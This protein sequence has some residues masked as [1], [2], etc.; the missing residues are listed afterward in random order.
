M[1]EGH[2][3]LGDDTADRARDASVRILVVDG[4]DG[5]RYLLGAVLAEEGF[6]ATTAQDG[7]EAL[8]VVASATPP[9]VVTDLMMPRLDGYT[10]I[11][12]LRAASV[13]IRRIIAMSAVS[14]AG[15]RPPGAD[16]FIAKPFDIE[17][18]VTSV[19]ALLAETAPGH[20]ALTA[21]R[22]LRHGRRHDDD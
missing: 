10:L 14:I 18:V 12:R 11:D 2:Q 15:T 6:R 17:Q 5:I 3:P 22:Y 19:F 4:E 8:R 7:I 9:D 16:L 21:A 13:S 20:P 1:P